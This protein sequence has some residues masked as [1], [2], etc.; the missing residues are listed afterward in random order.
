MY[1]VTENINSRLP[2]SLLPLIILPLLLQKEICIHLVM[3]LVVNLAMEIWRV[4][5]FQ[6]EFVEHLITREWYG[7]DLIFHSASLTIIQKV[8][9]ACGR[10]HTAIITVG[11]ELFTFGCGV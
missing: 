10:S 2:W 8:E 11:R 5:P 7:I 4:L 3:E 1:H 9:V 6:S